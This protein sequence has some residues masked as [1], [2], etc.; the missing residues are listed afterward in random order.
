MLTP[1]QKPL[2]PFGMGHTPIDPRTGR[3]LPLSQTSVV[4]RF[5]VE[6]EQDDYLTCSDTYGKTV[7]VAKPLMLR[8][9]PFDGLEIDD[10]TYA[11]TDST[12][13]TAN[14]RP[15]VLH[16]EYMPETEYILAVRFPSG[17]YNPIMSQSAE[18]ELELSLVKDPHER[19]IEWQDINAAGRTW[20]AKAVEWGIPKADPTNTAARIIT[21]RPC[22]EEGAEY[23]DAD[24]VDVY[25]R[26]DQSWVQLGPRG[27]LATAGDVVGTVLSFVRFPW[28]AAFSSAVQGVLV[29][30]CIPD[31]VRVS[32][33]DTVPG[34]LR[35]TGGDQQAADKII[36]DSEA[37]IAAATTGHW[38]AASVVNDGAGEYQLKIVHVGPGPTVVAYSDDYIELDQ[39][40]HVRRHKDACSCTADWVGPCA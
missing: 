20:G 8:K 25:V 17:V 35:Q 15:E 10:V 7:Y 5:L 16:P 29:G 39:Y 36:G 13:R 18:P 6:S 2:A 28:D 27:W 22:D 4:R 12:T 14:N 33:S 23:T 19:R 1:P 24:D 26:S 34:Y 37:D 40:G 11:Y 21:L 38:I 32:V 3:H 30:E 31:K 9:T